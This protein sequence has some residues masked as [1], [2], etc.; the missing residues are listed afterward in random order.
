[1]P[2]AVIGEGLPFL[3]AALAAFEC[4]TV[5]RYDVGDHLIVLGRVVEL[6]VREGGEPLVFFRS[7]YRQLDAWASPSIPEGDPFEVWG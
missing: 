4:E 7:R 5:A 6:M 2:H 3:E 1:V